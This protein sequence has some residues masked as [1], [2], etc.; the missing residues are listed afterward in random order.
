MIEIPF[1][2][3]RY[4]PWPRNYNASA[5]TK[6]A[7]F[8]CYCVS[9]CRLQAEITCSGENFVIPAYSE[10]CSVKRFDTGADPYGL[11]KIPVT[12]SKIGSLG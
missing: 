12:G 6:Y 10:Y 3:N 2:F 11:K 1:I 4:S 7:R 9:S 8:V 5:M